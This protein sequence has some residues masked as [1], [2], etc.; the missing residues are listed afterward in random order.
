MDETQRYM[1]QIWVWVDII[2]YILQQRFSQRKFKHPLNINPQHRDSNVC[3]LKQKEIPTRPNS[4]GRLRWPW[5]IP[6]ACI[7]QVS[8][9][10]KIKPVIIEGGLVDITTKIDTVVIGFTAGPQR[11]IVKVTSDLFVHLLGRYLLSAFSA[12][13]RWLR[14]RYININILTPHRPQYCVQLLASQ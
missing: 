13:L 6:R 2:C 4:L 12:S 14:N 5:R 8:F 10:K 11:R 3:Y 7:F 9:G 1:L